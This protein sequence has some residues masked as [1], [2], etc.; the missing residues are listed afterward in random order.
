[1]NRNLP[2]VFSLFLLVGIV[3]PVYAQT[4]DHV[5]I[6]ELDTNPPGNDSE[7]IA[8]WVEL[9]NPTDANVDL[10][11]WKIAS[12][13]VLKK[14]MTIPSG[15]VIKPGQFLTYTYQNLW[16]TDSNES[17]ELR[18]KNGL[19]IDKTPIL[20]DFQNDSTSWQRIYDGY[21]SDTL[22]DWKFVKSTVGS[23]NGKPVDTQESNGVTITVSSEKDSY[24][25]GE[26]AIIRGSVSEQVFTVKPYFQPQ[27]IIVT[28]TGPNFNKDITLY[29]DLNLNYKAT[30][31]LQQVLG[32]YEGTYHV[33]VAYAGASAST[34]F[35]VGYESPV[36]VVK[37]E[38]SLVLLTDKSQYFP[39]QSV[40]ITG[41][42]SKIIPYEGMKLI[43]KDSDG[44]VVSTG[45]LYPTNG[46]FKSTFYVSTVNV[47]YGTYEIY[48][49]YSDKATSINFDVIE[50]VKE[51]V[52]ISIW[53]DKVAYG[54]GDQVKITGRL[55]QQWISTLDLEIVQTK[56]TSIG[57]SSIGSNSGFKISDGVRIMGDGSFAY[58]FT[59]PDS[60]LRLGDYR[61]TVSKSIGTAT[62]IIHVVSS[63]ESFVDSDSVLT[64]NTDKEVYEPGDKMIISGFIKDSSIISGYK[65][66]LPV[67]ISVSHEDGT[68]LKIT[69]L[70]GVQTKYSNDVAVAY[71]FTAIPETSG[72]Y[73]LNVDVTRSIFTEGNYV[74]KSEFSSHVATKTFSIIDPLDLKDGAIISTDKDIYGLGETVHLAGIVP[75]TGDT[76]VIITL[77][78]P[79]GTKIV[80]GSAVDG[81]R[82]SWSWTVPVAEKVQNIKVNTGKDVVKSNF[83]VYKIKVSAS[84]ETHSLFFKV[85]ADP[86]HDTMSTSPVFVTTEKSLYQAG[87]K[88]KVI[89]NVLKRTQG[90][91]GLVINQRVTIKVFDDSFPA[92]QIYE[93]AVYPNQGGEFTSIFDLP[94]TIFPEGTYSVKAIYGGARSESTFSVA[95]D[96]T[97]GIDE[98]VNLLLSTDK[99]QYYPGD[100]VEIN[101]KPNK[102]IYIEK[103]DVSVIQKSDSEITCGTF[104]CGKHTGPVTTIRPNPSGS[105][106][107]QFTIPNTS[108]AIGSYEITVD[109]DFET[110]SI[111]FD[112]VEKPLVIRPDTVIEKENRI[113]T[114]LISIL[115]EEKTTDIVSIAPRVLTGSLMTPVRGDESFVNLKVS[116]STGICVI[117]PNDDCLVN[118]STRTPGQIYK[119]I[120]VDGASLN[121][122][123][124]GSDVRLEKFSILPESPDEFLPD[125]TWNVEILKN[126]QVSRFYYKITYKTLE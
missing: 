42:A 94:I 58:S 47:V 126:D 38:S 113:S 26:T 116:T 55:N 107:H 79:D 13:T 27:Q 46:E 64:V 115:T 103:F 112:V 92:K 78:K 82:F 49:E 102:L 125:E 40:M 54:L 22:F 87:D 23:S 32:I 10:G 111:L 70:S 36:Q 97:F 65:S 50:D 86:E 91:E 17:V 41:H 109:A 16:F 118:E 44:K 104:F 89:G 20:T 7:S 45:N 5:I 77:T 3:V 95:N 39:G 52:P 124:S 69:A 75:P 67:R 66:G 93:S 98:P 84:S 74:I 101:G 11:G 114:N 35:S 33:S 121:V 63:P 21:D 1:M 119:T 48:A 15:T 88:L 106:D 76:S 34:N 2:L 31:G 81:Q 123:Y 96:Y 37:T 9:Y 51:D 8:E 71:V 57:S 6:N 62:S 59:I 25:F 68:P 108:S 117:G 85:S 83:G 14:T 4:T 30:L 61:I 60:K 29:P 72:N 105:F 99:T 19:I 43:V 73:L 56:Q 80:S 53:T 12:T 122:R 110:K 100:V 18:D 24:L 28:I 90:D 120:D